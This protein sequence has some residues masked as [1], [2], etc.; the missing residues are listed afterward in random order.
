[1]VDPAA[2]FLANTRRPRRQIRLFRFVSFK[3][4]LHGRRS[5]TK[6]ETIGVPL[7]DP[8]GPSAE[9]VAF[10]TDVLDKRYLLYEWCEAK[11]NTLA[12][13]NSILIA[14][15]FAVTGTFLK[16]SSPWNVAAIGLCFG[17]ILFSLV[18]VLW[19]I[20]PT[21]RSGSFKRGTKNLRSVVGISEHK[22][23]SEYVD[24]VLG[25]VELRRFEA[26]AQQVYG[27]NKNIMR[28]QRAI[29]AAVIAD[30]AGICFFLAFVFTYFFTW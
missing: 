1:M 24:A 27:M 26:I 11:I 18:V 15:I 21:M 8:P 3:R 5:M 13:M 4:L 19:H 12:T 22:S 20:I 10:I 28:N 25:S 9:H 7:G 2:I 14:A 6:T 29:R 16:I 30:L 17:S 23:F